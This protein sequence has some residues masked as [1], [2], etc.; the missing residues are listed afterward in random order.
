[1]CEVWGR[2][3]LNQGGGRGVGCEGQTGSH[4]KGV[5]WCPGQEVWG[6]TQE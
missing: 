3:L 5:D 4:T 6:R 2:G 1:M